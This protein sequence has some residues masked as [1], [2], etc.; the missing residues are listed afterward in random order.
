MR[1]LILAAVLGLAAGCGQP[2]RV[3]ASTDESARASVKAIL[4]SLSEPEKSEFLGAAMKSA[5]P[6]VMKA[7][8]SKGTTKS[9]GAA[10]YKVLH[11]MTAKEA[12]AWSKQQ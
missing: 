12:I 3:D 2:L 1:W 6:F 8:F 10:M 4:D 5:M 7:S 9:D 11:G